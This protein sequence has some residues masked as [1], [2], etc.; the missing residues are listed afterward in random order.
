VVNGLPVASREIPAD[1]RA[2]D[3]DLEVDIRQSA[4]VALRHFPQLHTNPVDVL[5]GGRPIRVSPADALWCIETIEQL[6][7]TRERAIAEAERADARHAYDE[8]I[9]AFRRVAE[10]AG[11]RGGV[12]A[13]ANR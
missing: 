5:V 6:W 11:K 13:K 4:W 3:W 1:G 2:H 8:A 7:R 10:E 12:Q 9:A